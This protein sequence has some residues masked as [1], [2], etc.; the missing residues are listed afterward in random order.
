MAN[1][2]FYTAEEAAAKLGKSVEDLM[3]MAKRGEIQEFKQG[4]K[5]QFKVEQVHLLAGSDEDLGEIPLALEESKGGSGIDLMA[6]SFVPPSTPKAPPAPTGKK[7]PSLVDSSEQSGI[8]AFEASRFGQKAT[9]ESGISLEAAGSGSGLLD[10]TRESEDTQLGADLIAQTFEDDSSVEPIAN[11][12]GLFEAAGAESGGNA[13]I[14]TVT[15]MPGMAGGLTMVAEA[16]D[17]K[18]SG[19]AG[20]LMIGSAAAMILV[21]IFAASMSIGTPASLATTFAEN[22]PL[23]G[24]G[25]LGV[26]LVSGGVG[27]FIGKATE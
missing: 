26:L 7:T 16:Y 24:G 13:V 22:L 3:A 21:G 2:M 9:S 1:K 5:V 15:P 27:F 19:L 25:L 14:G 17:G 23:W 18:W 4:D 6:D 10:L 8:S 11:A 20:G 12:S